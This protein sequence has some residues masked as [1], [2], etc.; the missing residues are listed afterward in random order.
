MMKELQEKERM[1]CAVFE[2]ATLCWAK[3]V[4]SMKFAAMLS[5]VF[6]KKVVLVFLKSGHSHMKPDIGC[7]LGEKV[8]S[9]NATSTP[10]IIWSVCWIQSNQSKQ[11]FLTTKAP[12]LCSFLGGKNCWGRTSKAFPMAKPTFTIWIWEWNSHCE[13]SLF[14]AWQMEHGL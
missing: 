1:L 8:Q 12:N 13:K 10:H 11:S 2:C 5:I 7:G 3:Q 14:Y 6:F 4:A 9:K